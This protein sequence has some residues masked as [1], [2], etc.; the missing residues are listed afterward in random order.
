MF[1]FLVRQF[2][3]ID[4]IVPIAYKLAQDPSHQ[5]VIL[6][7]NLDFDVKGDF[8]LRFIE[9]E[10]GVFTAYSYHVYPG[11]W[12]KRMLC[13]CLLWIR[14]ARPEVL[15]QRIFSMLSRFVYTETWAEKLLE[16]FSARVLI[17]VL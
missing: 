6:C 8:R 4:H 13:A 1:L 2:P 16:H 9:K 5:V 17:S 11:S 15:G 3:D 10:L 12:W 7:Q 14:K